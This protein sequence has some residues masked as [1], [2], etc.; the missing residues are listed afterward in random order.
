MESAHLQRTNLCL[1][2]MDSNHRAS[3]RLHGGRKTARKM[4]SLISDIKADP[5]VLIAKCCPIATLQSS[6]IMR[7]ASR[8]VVQ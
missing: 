3:V 6:W 4:Y 1:H 5:V 2:Q 7:E 8:L